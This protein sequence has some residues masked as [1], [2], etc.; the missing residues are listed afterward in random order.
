MED[1]QSSA[2]VGKDKAKKLVE[3]DKVFTIVVLDRLENQQAIGAYLDG[4]KVPNIEI[5]TPANLAKSQT[6][7][8][9]VTIDH[10]VTRDPAGRPTIVMRSALARIADW[11]SWLTSLRPIGIRLSS[12][13][14]L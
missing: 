6:W 7:T 10:D 8:F 4:R 9:G 1:T 3:E 12:A 2:S 14:F 5:Q 13:T 11:L